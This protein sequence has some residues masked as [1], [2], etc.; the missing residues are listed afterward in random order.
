MSQ[1]TNILLIKSLCHTSTQT[2]CWK[3]NYTP[4]SWLARFSKRKELD[5]LRPLHVTE[6]GL[7]ELGHSRTWM[8]SCSD[9]LLAQHGY[10]MSVGAKGPE[11]DMEKCQTRAR[12]SVR[13]E[14]NPERGLQTKVSMVKPGKDGL[15]SLSEEQAAA[16]IIYVPW[17]RLST[18][19][20]R[21]G[22]KR[23]TRSFS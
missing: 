5:D 3:P 9:T 22:E 13:T 12:Q 10:S 20:D 17:L 1:N 2:L 21:S 11:L 6:A 16:I 7:G 19:E 8:G 4:K 23:T 15:C 18:Y 14:S